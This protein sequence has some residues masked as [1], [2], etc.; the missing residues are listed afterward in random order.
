MGRLNRRRFIQQSAMAGFGAG[1]IISGTS[2]SG[3]VT[4][5]NER[6][7]IAVAGINGR[8]RSH[9]NAHAGKKDRMVTYLIDP[10]ARLFEHRSKD[11]EKRQGGK[12]PTCVQDVRKA[13]E[14][15]NL[16][17]IS[18]ATCNHWHA[19][20]TIWACQHEKDVYVEKP[21]SHNVHEGRVAVEAARRYKRIVQHGTQQRSSGGRYN[22]MAA[23]ASGTYGKLTVAKGYCCKP[24]W[25]I[26]TKKTQKPPAKLDFNM[27]LGP[28][29]EQS[30]HGNLVHY[31]W[32]WF[33]DFGN[34]D[35]GNQGVHEMDVARWGIPGATLPKRVFALGGRFAYKDQGQTPNTQIAVYEYDD[36]LL[37]FE[38]RGLVGK[39]GVPRIVANEFYTTEGVIKGG[40]FFKHGSN[41]GESLKRFD[42]Q[43][44]PGNIFDNWIHA[45]RTRNVGDLHADVEKGHYSSALCHLANVSQRMGSRREWGGKA[46][47]Q[48]DN[49]IVA[50]SLAAARDNLVKVGVPVKGLKV[51]VGRV[52]NIDPATERVTNLPDANKL[53]TREYRKG[54][55]LPKI[56][57]VG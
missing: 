16:D 33:W 5:A 7:N 54:F 21:M 50:A 10:D 55:E 40:K 23:L 52:L 44:P 34:G 22:E 56:K 2:T 24:R 38:T 20:M 57:R 14:D 4:G 42:Y 9:Y 48:G 13:L 36:A 26:G 11:V 39:K 31:N 49:E 29:K 32:H 43:A 28:A 18:I 35:T 17:A 12:R 37:L 47:L 25:S 15:K 46:G 53:M 8:G 19:L 41:R 51:Q 6:I 45:I 30:Y 1:L 27:W 3:R